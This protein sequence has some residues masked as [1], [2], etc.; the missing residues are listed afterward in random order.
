MTSVLVIIQRK[1]N[2]FMKYI[3][4]RPQQRL[5][6]VIRNELWRSIDRLDCHLSREVIQ[7]HPWS[8]HKRRMRAKFYRMLLRVASCCIVHDA[9]NL[10]ETEWKMLSEL[11]SRLCVAVAKTTRSYVTEPRLRWDGKG[12]TWERVFTHTHTHIHDSQI[13]FNSR[14]KSVAKIYQF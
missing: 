6:I 4:R 7:D 3:H 13:L 8:I 1:K 14:K 10:N 2:L 9:C 11:C 5:L 12:P